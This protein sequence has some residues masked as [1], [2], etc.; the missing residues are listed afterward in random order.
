MFEELKKATILTKRDLIT[1]VHN[2]PKTVEEEYNL[3]LDR[4]KDIEKTK[5]IL[6]IIVA[7]Q[8]AMSLQ[9]MAVALDITNRIKIFNRTGTFDHTKNFN[10]SMQKESSRTSE[11]HVDCLSLS[12]TRREFLVKPL[13]SAP[14]DDNQPWYH[15]LCPM[16][17]NRILAEICIWYLLLVDFQKIYMAPDFEQANGQY[18]LLH[19]ASSNWVVHFKQIRMKRCDRLISSALKLCSPFQKGNPIWFKIYW[20]ENQQKKGRRV[21]PSGFDALMMASYFGLERVVEELLAVKYGNGITPLSIAL[22]YGYPEIAGQLIKKGAKIEAKDNYQRT[23][24]A[25]AAR[26]GYRNITQ[27]LL[28]KGANIKARDK[29]QRT[30][31]AIATAWGY[32][33]IIQLLLEK[34]ADI[35]ARDEDQRTP[36]AIA[37]LL[38][39][40]GADIEARDKD[41]MT[42]LALATAYGYIGQNTDT[43][44]LL[45]EKGADVKARDKDQ[46][47]PLEVATAFGHRDM[48]QLLLEK[49]I[50]TERPSR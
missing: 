9:E 17:S 37:T 46:M 29:N 5:K 40:N 49:G 2:L 3:I 39:E 26:W 14:V 7:A 44:Q 31:L 47:T 27:L 33:D 15:S 35:E 4:S 30:P 10:R 19:Y 20:K 1:C 41:Q 13:S 43:I 11:K 25:L 23:P 24:L 38:L 36:L 21:P 50:E 12:K 16:D 6:H 42:P 32:G 45:L 22:S 8:R 48:I 34:G 28:E 18:P